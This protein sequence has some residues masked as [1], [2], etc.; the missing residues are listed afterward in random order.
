VKNWSFGLQQKL[1]DTA[2]AELSYVGTSSGNLSYYKNINQLVAGTQQAH[3]GISAQAL[4][5]YP[6]YQDIFQS[7]NGAISNYNSLQARIQERMRSGGT[8]NVSYTWSKSLTDAPDYNYN[9]QDSFNL[10]AD[11][12]PQRYNQPQI[13]VVSY[14]YPLPFWQTGSEWYK[15]ALG[16]WSVSGITRISS[17]L[18]INVTQPA[19]TS[20]SGDGVTA[21]LERPNLVGNPFAGTGGKQYLNAA[22]FAL[23]AAGTFGNLQ[24][25]GI[26]GPHYDNW[27]ASVSKTF[28]IY[29]QV[30]IDFRAE[31]FNVP[32][33]LSA[34]TVS[35]TMGASNF[36]QVTVATDPRTMEFALKVHF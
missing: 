27:D 6:G 21:V 22:A 30:G 32:N 35:N 24:T 29:E 3:P 13:F 26:K 25:Y 16:K 4:R 34:F 18:P 14:V 8:V 5:P 15:K 33:H 11:Y 36:G 7:T 17:G 23:P 10:R 12:G 1:T 9:P 31:M 28:P 2:I 20:Q 19:N